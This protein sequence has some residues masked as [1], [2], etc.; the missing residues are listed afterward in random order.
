MIVGWIVW[1]SICSVAENSCFRVKTT[2]LVSSII[3]SVCRVLLFVGQSFQFTYLSCPYF[4]VGTAYSIFFPVLICSTSNRV[5]CCF[6]A[7]VFTI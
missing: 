1:F 4:K 5:M 3:L 6:K 2:R 7:I